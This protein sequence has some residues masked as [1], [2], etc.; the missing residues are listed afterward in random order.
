MVHLQAILSFTMK[1]L[2]VKATKK[3]LWQHSV[4]C[5]T[6][7]ESMGTKKQ[8]AIRNNTS[9]DEHW[10]PSRGPT[11]NNTRMNRTIM[12][13]VRKRHDSKEHVT[14]AP[15]M[16]TKKQIVKRRQLMKRMRTANKR[17]VLQRYLDPTRVLN[18]CCMLEW[19]VD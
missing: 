8:T 15:N 10:E 18:F 5:V 12:Q 11:V 1:R 2:Q 17:Q 9:M 14:T 4:E 7:V 16:G 13:R 6:G 3:L 19:N